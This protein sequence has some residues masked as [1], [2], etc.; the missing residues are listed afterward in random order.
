MRSAAVPLADRRDAGRLLAAEL[1]TYSGRADVIV[2]GLPR[3][4]AVVAFEVAKAL[5]VLLDVLTVRKLGVPG[6]EELAMGAVAT[7][8]VRVMNEDVVSMLRLSGTEIEAVIARELATLERREQAY[9][10]HSM[11]LELVGKV[12]ILVDDGLATGASMRT[13]IQVVKSHWPARVVVAVPV[14]PPDTC[15][16]LRKE[17]DEMVCVMTPEPFYSVGAWYI[18]F[19]QI[20]DEEVIDLLQEAKLFKR[21]TTAPTSGK[22][23]RHWNEDLT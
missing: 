19:D 5:K 12:V 1:T 8:G 14:A 16:A 22:A 10:G 18:D 7:G 2:L 3:G 4:G 13:A 11:P 21:D 6:Q 9:R 20:S 23:N 17:V 15:A